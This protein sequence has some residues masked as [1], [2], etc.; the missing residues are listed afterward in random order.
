MEHLYGNAVRLFSI[1]MLA[2]ADSL[3]YYI[4]RRLPIVHR[5]GE[6]IS[7]TQRKCAPSK[8]S[9]HGSRSILF[10][11][12]FLFFPIASVDDTGRLIVYHDK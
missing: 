8:L 9:A 3:F 11:L 1:F 2:A 12:F 4:D 10:V 5:P 7:Q 6:F